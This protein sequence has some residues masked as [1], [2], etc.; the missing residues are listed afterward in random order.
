LW[1]IAVIKQKLDYIHN[2]PV[3]AGFVTQPEHWKY[4]SA[5]NFA[6]DQTVM[7][8]DEIGFLG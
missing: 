7:Q 3:E 5:R 6:D 8:I 2:N 4:S 1:S